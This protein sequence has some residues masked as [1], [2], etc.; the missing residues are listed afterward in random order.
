M[1]ILFLK[2]ITNGNNIITF[3]S[4][5]CIISL[6]EMIFYNIGVIIIIIIINSLLIEGYIVS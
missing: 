1:G 4:N 2:S 5:P 6:D 3:L